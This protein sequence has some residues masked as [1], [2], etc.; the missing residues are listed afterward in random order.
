[1]MNSLG[2]TVVT[3]NYLH[4]WFLKYMYVLYI[5]FYL[6]FSLWHRITECSGLEGPLCIISSNPPAK[7]GSPRADCRGPRPGGFWI[8]PEETP[9]PPWEACSSAPSPSEWGSS[10][11]CSDGTSSASVCARCPLSYCWAPLKSLAPFLDTHRCFK[12]F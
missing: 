5:S 7:A 10:S 4:F 2:L 1:M 8:S 9:Q 12:M 11:S 3:R 6:T